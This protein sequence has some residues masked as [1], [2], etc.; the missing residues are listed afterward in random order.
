METCAQSL[1]GV[2]S[3]E[4]DYLLPYYIRLQRLADEVDQAFDY[5]QNFKLPQLDAM[6]IEILLK[7][8]EQQLSQIELTFP[9]NIW[10]NGEVIMSTGFNS[11]Y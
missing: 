6:R 2:A 7:V 10:N 11:I 3:A 4:T 1:V 5:S 9:P 8:F